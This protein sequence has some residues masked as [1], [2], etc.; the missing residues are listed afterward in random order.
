MKYDIYKSDRESII[1]NLKALE[2]VF[3][4]PSQ[5]YELSSEDASKF[6]IECILISYNANDDKPFQT[7]L[8]KH[9]ARLGEHTFYAV[10][11]TDELNKES[12]G[13]S[14]ST[15]MV[16]FITAMDYNPFFVTNSNILMCGDCGEPFEDPR[17]GDIAR[18]VGNDDFNPLFVLLD[19]VVQKYVGETEYQTDKFN[20]AVIALRWII[21]YGFPYR[22]IIDWDYNKIIDSDVRGRVMANDVPFDTNFIVGNPEHRFCRLIRFGLREFISTEKMLFER[23]LKLDLIDSASSL[24][25]FEIIKEPITDKYVSNVKSLSNVFLQPADKNLK[26]PEIFSPAFTVSMRISQPEGFTEKFLE[27]VRK[28]PTILGGVKCDL[29][30][31]ERLE[32]NGQ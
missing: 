15:Y 19:D 21:S 5:G 13:I 6:A 8:L 23:L 26:K 14:P 4:F 27:E 18:F 10:F 9:L 2:G 32:G 1:R 20:N 17:Y 11:E 16:N 3:V 25:F 29:K 24:L 22:N 31:V 30:P 12:K 7:S 28:H